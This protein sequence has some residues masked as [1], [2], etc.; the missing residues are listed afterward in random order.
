MNKDMPDWL[1]PAVYPVLLIC[2][3]ASV[4]ILGQASADADRD[5]PPEFNRPFPV[6][7]APDQSSI[8]RNQTADRVATVDENQ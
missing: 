1:R 2:I 8:D 7:S 4:W 6:A 3:I 5:V